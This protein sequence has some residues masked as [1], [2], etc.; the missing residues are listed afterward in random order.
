MTKEVTQASEA[1][2]DEPDIIY[3][4]AD[5]MGFG[6]MG[7]NHPG[8][9]IP[10]PNLDRLA[11]EGMRFTDA[12]A[13]SSVCTPSRYHILTGRY[14]WRSR[15]KRGVLWQWDG[16]LIEPAR[17]TVATM[18]RDHGYRTA[19]VGKWHLGWDWST[20]DGTHP[21][22]TLAFGEHLREERNAFGMTQIDFSKPLGGGPLA[23]GFESYF[24][25]DVPN[26]P[27]YAWIE[28]DRLPVLPTEEKPEAMYGRPGR[29]CTDWRLEGLLPELTQRAVTFI[30]EQ[31]GQPRPRRPY[32][33][34]FP[35]TAPHSPIVPNARF[36]GRSGAGAY[37][38]FV[39][40]V[41]WT[42]GQ[43]LAALQEAG[44]RRETL[45]I[46]T[47]DNGPENRTPDDEGAYARAQRH[48]HYSMGP[49]RGLKRDTWEG[50]HRV[51]FL[52]SWP[53]VIGPGTRCDQLI[54]LGDLMATCADLLGVAVPVGGGQDSLSFASLLRGAGHNAARESA[55]HHSYDGRFAVRRGPWVFIDAPTGDEN[56]EPDWFKQQRGYTVH[57][58]PGELYNVH[59]D[60][61]ERRNRYAEEPERVA[62]LR[63]I[64]RCACAEG[65]V[66]GG[67]GADI[68][69]LSE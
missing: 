37:G 18:L 5:D 1:T 41:D 8:G 43:V 52:A 33:L 60:L 15:L 47:S 31:A 59:D 21:N 34:Y 9:K 11:A 36:R 51:P 50:G 48:G 53:G 66:H 54:C 14:A 42:V 13:G 40:E 68:A 3:I 63:E 19:C 58:C 55:I 7:C 45:V 4:L 57:D 62:E 61:P 69:A 29:A 28:N 27:P 24:G 56:D 32:F 49:L 2:A 30:T 25:V 10:T 35:L 6:D 12:H 17:P 26:F 67:P 20:V 65:D 46:F 22:A 39:C 16:P 64:L 23:C 38:D 44:T